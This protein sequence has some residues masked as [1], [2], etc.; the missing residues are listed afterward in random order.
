M[1]ANGNKWWETDEGICAVSMPW[2]WCNWQKNQL[3]K[4]WVH[5]LETLNSRYTALR[6][7]LSE[8]VAFDKDLA[9]IKIDKILWEKWGFKDG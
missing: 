2:W 9:K 6:L 5:W 7:K 3:Y 4:T 8:C 1:M